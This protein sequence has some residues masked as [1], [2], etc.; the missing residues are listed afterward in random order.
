MRRRHGR[1]RRWPDGRLFVG[2]QNGTV[3]ALDAKTGCVYWTFSRE[4]RRAHGADVRTADGLDGHALYLRRHRRERL[5]ARRGHRGSV[6]WSRR[7]DEHP[8]AR[9]TGSPT[10]YQG[11]ALRSGLVA[12]GD[13][14]EPAGLRVLHVPRQP[15]RAR[16]SRPASVV[17]QTLHGAAAAAGRQER[18][19][20]RRLWGPSGVG[21]WSAPT[22]DAK[23][24][25]VYVG[26]GNTYSGT[27]AQPT[28]DA[29]IAFD[30]KT[31]AMKWMKQLTAGRRLRLPRRLGEL[32]REGRPRLRLRDAG[33]AHHPAPTAATSSSSGRS[34]A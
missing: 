21:I 31:G 16:R 27:A 8:F 12:R 22:I 24:G 5:R 32:R 23:R 28:S 7:M 15:E 11:S 13:R 1:S 14:G 19:G 10:L 18:R 4:E 9:V 17:W 20:R 6:L 29:I 2:S 26:T 25:L 34:R 3:Y 30:P 33:D